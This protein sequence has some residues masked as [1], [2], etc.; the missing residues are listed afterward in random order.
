MKPLA[1]ISG[2]SGLVFTR[3]EIAFFREFD[4]WGLILFQR[5][6]HDHEQIKA[7]ISSFRALNGRKDAPV[8][9]DQEG[10]RVQRLQPP[11][12]RQYPAARIFGDIFQK[13]REEGLE[14]A[15]LITR[16]IAEDLHN[17]GINVDCLPVAD[18][19]RHDSD[20]IIGDRSYASDAETVSH[21]ARAAA[22]ALLEG[23]VLPVIKHIPGHGR[24]RVDSHL[25]LPVVTTKAETL[26]RTDFR[27]FGKLS[28]LPLAMTAHVVYE[29]FDSQHPAT[30]SAT[31]IT[32]VIRGVM[33]FDGLLMSDDLSMKA[34]SGSFAH[35]T[36][37]VFAAGCDVVLHCNGDMNEMR[38]VAENT[39][40]LQAKAF[41][42]AKAA[43]KC[44]NYPQNF[45]RDRALFV[46]SHLLQN[47]LNERIPV[48]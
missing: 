17:L 19:P 32:E 36:R 4:P 27:P 39:P 46:H 13:D 45:D 2:C 16:L 3:D 29:A 37:Q 1:L 34:L 38:Q 31:I 28:D 48:G 7:L 42:R 26:H 44:L 6:C 11:L 47:S 15:Y 12:W 10:G 21:L 25:E 14:A 43:L 20:N 33:G 40:R 23:G 35:R 22:T 9:I 18:V 24:A 30:L 41:E 8:L 5:N